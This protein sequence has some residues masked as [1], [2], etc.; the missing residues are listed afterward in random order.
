[1]S[2][3]TTR[4]RLRHA[5]A[6][7]RKH[8]ADCRRERQFLSATSFFFTFVTVR[9]ITHSIRAG[10]GPFRNITPGGRHIHHMTF[11]IT[12]LLAVG[13][14]WMLEFGINASD[15]AGSRATS[16]AYGAGAALTLDEFALWLNLQDDYWTQQGRESIDAVVLFGTLLTMGLLGKDFIRELVAVGRRV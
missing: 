16:I 13:Y 11:G 7:Y 12:G 5:P 2:V 9:V 15:R 6:L 10:I 3:R 4:Q 14:L 1:M 8:F